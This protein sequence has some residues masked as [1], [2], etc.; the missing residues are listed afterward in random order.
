MDPDEVSHP[1]SGSEGES[2]PVS[3]RG[4]TAMNSLFF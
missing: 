1:T 2:Y 3:E 4:E